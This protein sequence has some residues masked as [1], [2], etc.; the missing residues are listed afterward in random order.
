DVRV[1]RMADLELHLRRVETSAPRSRH[2]TAR[3]RLRCGRGV[4]RRQHRLSSRAR[5]R[6]TRRNNHSCINRDAQ[7]PRRTRRAVDR[8]RNREPADAEFKTPGHPVTTI[9]FTLAC[10]T[11]VIATIAKAPMQS[12]IELGI[13]LAGVPAYL[14]WRGRTPPRA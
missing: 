10:W 9:V 14:L 6:R 13:M 2:R 7:S 4:C 12:A 3:R 1:R 11:V 5:R 8:R